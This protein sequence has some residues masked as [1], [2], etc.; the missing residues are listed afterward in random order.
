MIEKSIEN[1]SDEKNASLF[2][3]DLKEKKGE[4]HFVGFV[5]RRLEIKGRPEL[6]NFS[7]NVLFA[8]Y[9]EI[10]GHTVMCSSL[11]HPDLSSFKKKGGKQK[12][13]YRNEYNPEDWLEIIYNTKTGYYEGQKY[14]HNKKAIRTFGVGWQGFFQHFTMFGLSKGETCLYERIPTREM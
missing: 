11:Y 14:C 7:L 5:P 2:W 8:S 3:K 13:Y 10:N 12:M 9:T 1:L 6:I 4:R